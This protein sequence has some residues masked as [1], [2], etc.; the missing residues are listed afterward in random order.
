MN[1]SDTQKHHGSND[2]SADYEKYQEALELENNNEN[3][4]TDYDDNEH[5]QFNEEE[6][7]VEETIVETEKPLYWQD[8]KISPPENNKEWVAKPCPKCFQHTKSPTLFIHKKGH[9]H[10]EA[11]NYHGDAKVLPNSFKQKS[12]LPFELKWWEKD[13]SNN[14][15]VI[16]FFHEKGIDFDTLKSSDLS[17]TK[18]YFHQTKKYELALALPCRRDPE[19]N[20]QDVIYYAIDLKKNELTHYRNTQGATII[21]WGWEA[22]RNDEAILVNNPLDRLALIQAGYTSVACL[23]NGLDPQ[24]PDNKSWEFLR[25]VEHKINSIDKVI[26][27]FEDTE[28]GIALEE[29]IGRRIDKSKCFRVRYE[30]ELENQELIRNP[31]NMLKYFGSALIN[32]VI[33]EAVPFPVKG[34]YELYDVEDRFEA[35]YEFGMPGGVSTGW[36]SLDEHYTVAAGQWTLVT[37]IPGHGK[38]SFLDAL[39][40]NLAKF[41][42]W[43]IGI[44]SPENQPIERHFAGLMEKASGKLFNG[45]KDKRL[46]RKEKDQWK[47]WIHKHFKVI[48]PEDDQDSWSVDGVL[49]LAKILVYRYGIKGLVI[50]P[51]NELDHNR[52]SY[53]SETEHISSSLTKIRRFAKNFGVHVWIVA[54][55]TK[56]EPR[57]DGKYPVPTPY[58]VAGGAHW[59]NKADN[60]ISVYR[61][62]GEE[63]DDITD[64]HV[65][66]IRF[67]E[68]GKVGMIS[69]RADRACG[70]YYDDLNQSKRK[71]ALSSG[72]TVPSS[73][74]KTTLRKPKSGFEL[75]HVDPQNGDDIFGFED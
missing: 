67:K 2:G 18:Q 40:I 48:L 60:S 49:N 71:A 32:D 13:Y 45:P 3:N 9:F 68:V 57:A 31:L 35:L 21:P 50:D 12:P 1:F 11:C 20:Y 19:E 43:K 47:S 75:E 38:S 8:W 69:L 22:L 30:E 66:K 36:P 29:E 44:F 65:Q 63:D 64:I 10:C 74:I 42:E 28:Q 24:H 16:N 27:A 62:V 34:V 7:I 61:N 51:W 39:F 73:E 58:S 14:Q 54:H 72:K 4:D 17:I 15:E 55:P 37:G 59:R 5:Y 56:L 46:D 26:L 53:M 41:H 52:A 70:C 23:P 6:N 25:Q 33:E